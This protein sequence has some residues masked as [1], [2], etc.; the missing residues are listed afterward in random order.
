MSG[1]E[2][3]PFSDAD[4][5]GENLFDDLPVNVREPELT[6]LVRVGQTFMVKAKAMKNRGLQIVDMNLVLHDVESHLVSRTVC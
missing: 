3:T 6:A 2:I 1:S 4:L 5:S